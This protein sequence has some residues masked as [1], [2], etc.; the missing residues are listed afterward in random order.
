[1]NHLTEFLIINGETWV[2]LILAFILG[3]VIGLEREIH[4]RPAGLRTH[5]L[6]CVSA[7]I[8]MLAA[9]VHTQ[10]PE[11]LPQDIRITIDP[12]RIVAGIMTGIGF[13]GAGAII[14]IGEIIRGITTAACIWFVAAL[15][16]I[17]GEGC[18][19]LAVFSTGMVLILLISLQWLEHYFHPI[20]YHTIQIT[21]EGEKS[22]ET[23]AGCQKIFKHED[24]RVQNKSYSISYEP[25]RV[26]IT[27]N[28]RLKDR[29]QSGSVIRRIAKIPGVLEAIWR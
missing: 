10:L 12:G 1:M 25:N 24:I 29:G 26:I 21:T 5:I 16:I 27:F 14:R 11:P 28:V 22:Q 20:V 2:R 8:I 13:L 18:Y 17:I 6:V 23:E 9:K 3:G 4:G 15:G 19:V 7:T